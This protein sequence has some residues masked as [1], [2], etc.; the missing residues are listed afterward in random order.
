[1]A[2]DIKGR[3]ALVT[4]A[5]RRVGR[6]IALRLADE[7]AS[8]CLH[9]R[10]SEQEAGALKAEVEARGAKAWL[11]RADFDKGEYEGLVKRAAEAAGGL[12]I[13]VNNAS[14]FPES[15]LEDMSFEGLMSNIRVNAWAPFVLM[16]ELAAL[17]GGKVVNLLDARTGGYDWAHAEYI[18][19][20]H[21]FAELTRMCAAAFAP[22]VV[23][24][25]INPGLIL[26]P[27]GRGMD[28]LEGMERTVPLK[29]FGS[30]AEVAEAAIYLLRSEFLAGEVINVDGGRHLIEHGRG[31][32]TD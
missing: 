2:W 19:S 13:L 31:P 32:H 12:D 14:V 18:L 10:G 7:G 30:P 1:M 22:G 3:R 8:V 29:R 6:Q 20:K 5:A 16:R 17:G 21:L 23:V 4:G 9:Y 28:Y 24:N 26:P 27:P 25:G 11:L 15:R